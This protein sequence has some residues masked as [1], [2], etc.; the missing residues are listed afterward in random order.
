MHYRKSSLIWQFKRKLAKYL[1]SFKTRFLRYTALH[2]EFQNYWALSPTQLKNV[3]DL[4]KM[5]G[6]YIYLTLW[7]IEKNSFILRSGIFDSK[8]PLKNGSRK[9]IM[10]T[11]TTK[12]TRDDTVGCYT[13]FS[14]LRILVIT[15]NENKHG[16]SFQDTMKINWIKLKN[17]Q[18]RDLAHVDFIKMRD[19]HKICT[20]RAN[21]HPSCNTGYKWKDFTW[22]VKKF[23]L[24]SSLTKTYVKEPNK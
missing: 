10:L 17:C 7:L 13:L 14:S 9:N 15:T 23:F 22:T 1:Y 2:L 3:G 6:T 18:M 8:C 5:W 21:A 11:N 24:I 16:W 20:I 4:K 19:L 12:H